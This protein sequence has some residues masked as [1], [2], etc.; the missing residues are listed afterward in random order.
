MSTLRFW[1][2]VWL[3]AAVFVISAGYG[4]LLPQW[5]GWLAVALL[6]KST[7]AVPLRV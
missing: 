7:F 4:A 6:N 1:Q 2:L 5:Q 3:A